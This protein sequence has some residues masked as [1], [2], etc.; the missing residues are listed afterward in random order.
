MVPDIDSGQDPWQLDGPETHRGGPILARR[1]RAPVGRMLE[2]RRSR[3]EEPTTSQRID[4]ASQGWR[5]DLGGGW[6]GDMLLGL[7]AVRALLDVDTDPAREV[8][9]HGPRPEL[10][11]RCSLPVI[12]TFREGVHVF[13]RPGPNPVEFAPTPEAS[14]IWLD[15]VDDDVVAVHSALPMRY[16]LDMEYRLGRRLPCDADPIPRFLASS[17]HHDG[18]HVVLIVTTSMPERKDYGIA[19]YLA[20]AR[21]LIDHLGSHTHFTMVTAP[22]AAVPSD[23]FGDLP[24]KVLAGIDAVDCVDLFASARLVIGNDTGLTHLAALSARPDGGGPEVIGIYGRHS[25]TKWITGS[26]RHHAVTTWFSRMLAVCDRDAY[27]DGF[28]DTTW[29]DASRIAELSPTVV[30]R[31]AAAVAAS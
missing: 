9:Y 12:A 15:L 17:S 5:L 3:G 21:L 24:I 26:A 18:D 7:G 2:Y 6:L 25:H 29:G 14:Q 27:R 28:A 30:A 4:L 22:N 20:V 10:I 19:Q 23:Q 31:F 11:E 1:N 16:Y 13:E 8:H